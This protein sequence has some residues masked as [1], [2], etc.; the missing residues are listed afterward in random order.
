MPDQKAAG[1]TQPS[2][3]HL[4][5]DL[6]KHTTPRGTRDA[7]PGMP[8]VP[9]EVVEHTV[10]INGVVYSWTDATADRVPAEA[11]AIYQRSLEANG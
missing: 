5:N 9:N 6:L 10:S 3:P 11:L 7:F 1:E 4:K 2:A 8:S